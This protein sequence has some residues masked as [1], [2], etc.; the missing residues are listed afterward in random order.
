MPFRIEEFSLREDSGGAGK[1]RGGLGFRKKYR[2]LAPAIC[3]TNLDRT[4]CPPW[5]VQG[6]KEAKPGRFTVIKAAT[7]EEDD[8]RQGRTTIRSKPATRLRRNRRRRRLRSCLG[9]RALDLIQRDVDRWLCQPAGRRTAITASTIGSGR[10][11][12]IGRSAYPAEG[13][14]DED[15]NRLAGSSHRHV[16]GR[17]SRWLLAMATVVHR[18]RS[19]DEMNPA[20]P[21]KDLAAAANKEGDADA[22]LEPVDLR[23]PARRRALRS[24]HEQDVR[25]QRSHQF[26]AGRRTWRASVNQLATEYSAGQKAMS[27]SCSAPP[28]RWP[29]VKLD[30]SSNR[31]LE[32]LSAVARARRND[33][34]RQQAHPHRRPA[35]PA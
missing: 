17:C 11:G 32:Q 20:R 19:A 5:G 8:R 34:A 4:H 12:R 14:V 27:T 33:R 10:Q 26:R 29:V 2:M 9:E 16:E 6:G 3:D 7:G 31:R 1:F 13:A 30:M 25:H 15:S 18:W 22:E 28:R 35:F 21:I 23:R 24:R